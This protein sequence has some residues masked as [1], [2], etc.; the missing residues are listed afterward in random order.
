MEL[1]DLHVEVELPDRSD[2]LVLL[3]LEHRPVEVDLVVLVEDELLEPRVEGVEKR[4]VVGDVLLL[5]EGDLGV[6][7][8]GD[9]LH[10]VGAVVRSEEHTS[11]LQSLMRT[12]Y[13]VFCLKKKK[14]K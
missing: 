4:L 13:A 9:R 8:A 7:P 10:P 2:P 12:S 6:Q 11:E 5:D 3:L 1:T 14:H